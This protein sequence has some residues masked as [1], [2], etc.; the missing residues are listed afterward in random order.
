MYVI[1][2]E[3]VTVVCINFEI[4]ELRKTILVADNWDGACHGK[5]IVRGHNTNIYEE[6]YVEAFVFDA[7]GGTASKEGKRQKR[8]NYDELAYGGTVGVG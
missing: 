8:D 2:K 1:V 6:C 5:G 4:D 3:G 7:Y